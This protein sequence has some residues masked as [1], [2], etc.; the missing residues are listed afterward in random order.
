MSD[1][2]SSQAE[3]PLRNEGGLSSVSAVIM[4]VGID[5]GLDQVVLD[6]GLDRQTP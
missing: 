5:S 1:V 6:S 4:W 2:M 3:I